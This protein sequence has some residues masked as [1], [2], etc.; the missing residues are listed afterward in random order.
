MLLILELVL[1]VVA[2]RKGWRALALL[3]LAIGVPVGVFVTTQANSLV[4]AFI[5]DVLITI[6][7]IAMSAKGRK[8][9]VQP[10]AA[11]AEEVTHQNAA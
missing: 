9:A 3:P 8:P 11:P 10:V 4:P 1:T 6:T 5:A 2:W 7:L